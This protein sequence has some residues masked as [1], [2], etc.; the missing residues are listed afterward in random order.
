MF[1]IILNTKDMQKDEIV[2]DTSDIF[3]QSDPKV[4]ELILQGAKENL[5]AITASKDRLSNKYFIYATFCLGC[6]AFMVNGYLQSNN[7][8]IVSIFL[9]L[10]IIEL[11]FF[12]IVIWLN[13]KPSY[14]Y[15]EGIQASEVLCNTNLKQDYKT[16]LLVHI[17]MTDKTKHENMKINAKKANT[18]KW[19]VILNPV[20]IIITLAL[21]SITL[22]HKN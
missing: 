9:A 20:F 16:N 7:L 13:F 6:I 21:A 8:F 5:N 15:A 10:S 14:Y 2:S 18:L 12:I 4:L 11:V 1:K 22:F 3:K 17:I 19:L